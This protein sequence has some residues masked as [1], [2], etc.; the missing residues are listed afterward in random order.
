MSLKQIALSCSGP[1]LSS[2]VLNACI[3]RDAYVST[4]ISLQQHGLTYQINLVHDTAV[5]HV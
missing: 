1:I 4:L 2:N 5:L 3:G